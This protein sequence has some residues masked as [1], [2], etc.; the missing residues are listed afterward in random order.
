MNPQ[1]V[2]VPEGPPAAA[3]H[4]L[5]QAMLWT[6]SLV[7][8]AVMTVLVVALVRRPP[9]APPTAGDHRAA[10]SV[11]LAVGATVLTLVG[12]LV[13]SLTT[14][15][16][17]SLRAS[18]A[19]TVVL[20]GHQWWWEMEYEEAMPSQRVVTANEMH[21]PVNQP[22][23]VKV[24]S[25][26]VIHSFWVPGLQGKRDLIP[27]YT[28][29]MWIQADNPGVLRGQ[30]AEFCGLQHAHMALTVKAEPAADFAR[31]LASM[32]Q[33]AREPQGDH[34]R[35]GQDLFMSLRCAGC[36]TIGGTP[37]HGQVA[38]DLTHVGSRQTI[39]AGTLTNTPEH[40]KVWILNPQAIKPGNQM[41]AT[42]LAA[43]DLDA[44]VAYLGRLQ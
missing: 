6:S 43:G 19:V 3:I 1:T 36:H 29:A 35:R 39:A 32:R 13:A 16:M 28:T 33:P 8:V 11:G 17:T 26:D 23:V 18:S 10:K 15:R 22:V 31:W 41:P 7:F 25:R 40:L 4:A 9:T 27:G 20:S 24:T 34:E 14:G 2:L 44:L 30:C 37:A 42:P 12:L 38:P 5:W 21:I